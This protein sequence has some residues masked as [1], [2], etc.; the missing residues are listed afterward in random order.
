MLGRM[1]KNPIREHRGIRLLGVF[2][3]PGICYERGPQKEQGLHLPR[4]HGRYLEVCKWIGWGKGISTPLYNGSTSEPTWSVVTI[5]LETLGEPLALVK[6]Q[7]ITDAR[8][9]ILE[10]KDGDKTMKDIKRRFYDEFAQKKLP[11]ISELEGGEG[12][13]DSTGVKK[14][15]KTGR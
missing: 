13:H 8:K 6:A 9:A 7:L 10:G 14:K 1:P 12:V 11:G 5:A 2:A 3:Q 15:G 4:V